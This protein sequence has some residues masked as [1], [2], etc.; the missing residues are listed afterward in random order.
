MPKQYTIADAG[1]QSAQRTVTRKPGDD[2]LD[3]EVETRY[4]GDDSDLR[5]SAT[6]ESVLDDITPAREKTP[7][8]ELD[9]DEEDEDEEDSRESA[10]KDDDASDDDD[11]RPVKGSFEKRLARERRLLQEAREDTKE[12][13]AELRHFKE[14][15][16]KKTSDDELVKARASTETTL[17]RLRTELKAAFEDGNT[18]DQVRLTE[19]IADAKAELR[20]LEAD[21]KRAKEAEASAPETGRSQRA[22]QQ[23]IRKHAR[24]HTDPVFRA[25][26][27]ALDKQLIATGSDN[28][29]AEHY[30]GIDKEL[31]RRFPEEYKKS[32]AGQKRRESPVH[33]GRGNEGGQRTIAG[34]VRRGKKIIISAKQS[35]NMRRFGLDPDSPDDVKSYVRENLKAS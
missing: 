5:D 7:R 8:D 14:A 9:L 22:A 12:I 23:W 15:V 34:F 3:I 27:I 10:E 6:G 24:Y 2:D 31:A 21:A 19:E 13:L 26:A 33:G 28:A 16:V 4:E 20:T 11:A 18:D 25:A 35:D 30:E 29:T 1:E 17:G 32:A